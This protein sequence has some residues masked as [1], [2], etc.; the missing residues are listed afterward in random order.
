[1]GFAI[2]SDLIGAENRKLEAAHG[3][4]YAALGRQLG[5]RG[6]DIE[7]ITRRAMDFAVAIPTWGV[8]TGGTRFARFPGPGEPRN[9]FDKLEDCGVVHQLSRVTPNVSPHFPWDKVSDYSALRQAAAS[10]DLGFDAVNSNTFQDQ[11]GQQHSY[12]FGSL[13]H[14][15]EATRRQAIEHNVECIEIG[16]RL[17]SSAITVWIA[18]GSN[19][20]GQANL[21]TAFD[22]YVESMKAIYEHLP[23]NWSLLLEHKLYEPAFYSTVIGDWGTSLMAATELG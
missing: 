19:F 9:I 17:G 21:N 8:G 12:K 15:H 11:K 1:M 4:D 14:P 16:R 3:E 18:D 23:K 22:R 7:W 20:P 2:S 5:R 13:T 6:I 10:Y